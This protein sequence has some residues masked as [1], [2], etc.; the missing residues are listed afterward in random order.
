[1]KIHGDSVLP[2]KNAAKG[3]Q[4]SR[5]AAH[6]NHIPPADSE[7]LDVSDDESPIS[8]SGLDENNHKRVV[9]AASK[10]SVMNELFVKPNVFLVSRPSRKAL[11]EMPDRYTSFES[12]RAAVVAELY[13]ELPEDHHT[14][15]EN[16]IGFKKAVSGLFI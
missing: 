6:S 1:M 14:L 8:D 12:K 9:S 4:K 16:N 13:H 10:F 11:H 3:G 7:I 5:K 2:S 15:L